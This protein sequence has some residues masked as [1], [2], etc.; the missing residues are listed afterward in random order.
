MFYEVCKRCGS[1]FCHQIFRSTMLEGRL[2]PK[3]KFNV[4]KVAS[5]LLSKIG[6]NMVNP[7]TVSWT[8]PQR[9]QLVTLRKMNSYFGSDCVYV[10]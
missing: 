8:P 2:V 9:A 10:P 3:E 6:R 4:L 5:I 1:D 7:G